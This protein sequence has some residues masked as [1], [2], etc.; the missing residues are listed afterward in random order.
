MEA[1]TSQKLEFE[2]RVE[3]SPET[4][5]PFFTDPVKAVQ[6]MGESA[7][8]DPR[9]G[10]VYTVTMSN[11]WVA[12]GE[13]VEVDPPRRVVFTWGWEGDEA[14]TPPG[15]STVEIDLIPDGDA[16]LVRL[17]HSGLPNEA[18]AGHRDGWENFLPRLAAVATGRDPGP[19]PHKEEQS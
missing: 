19:N 2:I 10:G 3:A 16:T 8:L 14:A 7:T 9:P 4:I 1:G 18:A 13:F 17:V 15:S 5:F 11:Q 12:L 6:W